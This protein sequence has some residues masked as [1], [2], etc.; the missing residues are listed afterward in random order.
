MGDRTQALDRLEHLR[1][2]QPVEEASQ[3]RLG[4]SSTAGGGSPGGLLASRDSLGERRPDDLRD[5][6]AFATSGSARPPAGARLSQYCGWLETQ[7]S[8]SASAGLFQ[9]SRRG[10]SL[11][12]TM[13]RLD[14]RTTSVSAVSSPQGRLLVVAVCTGR[15]RRSR[16]SSA[17]RRSICWWNLR[18]RETAVGARH[19][20]EELVRARRRE[21]MKG[22][23]TILSAASRRRRARRRS[24]VRREVDSVLEG[25]LD[26]GPAPAPA[27]PQPSRSDTSQADLRTRSRPPSLRKFTPGDYPVRWR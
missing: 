20:E 9:P 7:G 24:R 18:G 14:G 6:V 25:G 3:P 2:D 16:S 12:T 17:Q 11:K 10:H 1:L 19:R 5:F 21:I 23:Q 26:A 15:G 27:P 22:E 4:L 8:T 13:P